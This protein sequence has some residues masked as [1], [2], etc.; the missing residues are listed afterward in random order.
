MAKKITYLLGAG[1]SA[2]T[3]PIVADMHER[4]KEMALYFY[5]IMRKYVDQKDDY[6]KMHDFNQELY[7]CLGVL[8]KI[9]NDLDWLIKEAGNY[10]TIDTLAKK[11]YLT[12]EYDNLAKLKK[13]LITYFTLEQVITV[14]TTEKKGYNFIKSNADKRYGNFIAAITHK[15]Y[16]IAGGNPDG[17]AAENRAFGLNNHIKILSWNYDMQFEITLQLFSKTIIQHIKETFQILPNRTSKNEVNYVN[18]DTNKFAM[19][20][21]NGDAIWHKEFQGQINK[22]T[23]FDGKSNTNENEK[24]LVDF[25]KAYSLGSLEKK[26]S[27]DDEAPLTSFNFAWESDSNYRDK[28]RGHKK[29]FEAAQQIASETEILVVI[30]YSFPVFNR[31]ID[32]ILFNKMKKLKKIYI[33]DKEP[34]KIQSTMRNAFEILQPKIESGTLGDYDMAGDQ[35]VEFH[36]D[37][38]INQFIIPF[39]LNQ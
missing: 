11:F 4:M 39:E 32:N 18:I 8:D 9:Y 19:V 22:Y 27:Y 7:N 16:P 21:L 30:G 15:R 34:E 37:N 33:Q 23:V 6:T 35:L 12:E 24:L 25:L 31:E 28:Y 13:C 2:N 3:I 36:L 26:V 14:P 10:Y 17:L 5:R 38:S 20:K 1:S 29:N